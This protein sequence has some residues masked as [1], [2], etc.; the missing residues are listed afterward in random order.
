MHPEFQI[1]GCKRLFSKGLQWHVLAG[2]AHIWSLAMGMA[3]TSAAAGDPK[4]RY[5]RIYVSDS[6]AIMVLD[7][8][9]DAN[10]H[11]L[12]VYVPDGWD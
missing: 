2:P 6:W 11:Y 7:E 4:M 9:S 10:G 3:G 5:F 1:R 12:L 8:H